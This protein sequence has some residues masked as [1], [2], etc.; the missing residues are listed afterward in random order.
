MSEQF[1]NKGHIQD[2]FSAKMRKEQTLWKRQRANVGLNQ[3]T[4]EATPK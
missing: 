4:K 3:E 2:Y 1:I